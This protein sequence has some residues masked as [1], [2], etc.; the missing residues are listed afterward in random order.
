[1]KMLIK[2]HEVPYNKR[3]YYSHPEDDMVVITLTNLNSGQRSVGRIYIG[4][5]SCLYLKNNGHY[6]RNWLKS[7]ITNLAET[8]QAKVYSDG[9]V[10][11]YTLHP[12]ATKFLISDLIRD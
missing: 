7:Q 1:M 8:L 3:N 12:Q 5:D 9:S 6:K 10:D 11:P 4:T 2:T